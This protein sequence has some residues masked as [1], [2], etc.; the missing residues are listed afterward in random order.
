[1]IFADGPWLVFVEV[2]ARHYLAQGLPEE[3]VTPAKLAT[4]ERVGQHYQQKTHQEDKLARI[5]VVAIEFIHEPP[6]L[7][8]LENVTG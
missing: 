5:D 3:A 4:I 8:H 7:R 6:V 2:K 1:M